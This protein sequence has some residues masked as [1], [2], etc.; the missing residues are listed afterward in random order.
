MCHNHQLVFWHLIG[1]GTTPEIHSLRFQDH[2][3]Q[4]TDL[5]NVFRLNIDRVCGHSKNKKNVT[6]ESYE[7]SSS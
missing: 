5:K 2:S 1:M 3:L 6:V 7:Q 4:V